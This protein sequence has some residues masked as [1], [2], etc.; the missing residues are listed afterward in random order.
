M[1]VGTADGGWA[2]MDH[3]H[4]LKLKDTLELHVVNGDRLSHGTPS[5]AVPTVLS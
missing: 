4:A 5:S 2:W 3:F 1:E